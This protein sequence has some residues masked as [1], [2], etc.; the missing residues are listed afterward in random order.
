MALV[1]TILSPAPVLFAYVGIGDV[2]ITDR[3]AIPKSEVVFSGVGED[4]TLS[5]AG[6]TQRCS[7]NMSLPV[8]FAYALVDADMTLIG[9]DAAQWNGTAGLQIQNNN[10]SPSQINHVQ[11]IS[12]GVIVEG[13]R[14]TWGFNSPGFPKQIISPIVNSA[15]FIFAQA[16]VENNTAEQVAMTCDF[17]FRWFQY[18]IE[19]AH[20]F[21]VNQALL[22]R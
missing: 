22:V 11:G 17:Y 5:G 6:D 16:L 21:A 1:Q 10:A 9:T 13:A 2:L 20:H 12:N 4:V 14:R 3:S 7:I 8:N 19:Q 15:S 18:D